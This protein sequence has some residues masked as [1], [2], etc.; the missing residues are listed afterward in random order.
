MSFLDRIIECN[1][2]DPTRFRPFIV[3]GQAVGHVRHEFAEHLT[4]F[5]D[6]FR[7]ANDRVELAADLGSYADRTAA[8]AT[9]LRQLERQGLIDASRHEPF[10][11]TT[12]FAAPALFE[13]ERTAVPYFGLRAFGLHMTG[14]VRSTKGIHLWIGRRSWTK[15][16]CPGMLDNTVAGGQ[17]VGISLLD[18][19]IKECGEEAG[20]PSARARQ[21]VPVGCISYLL[22]WPQGLKPDAMFCYDLELPAD[23]TPKNQDG[24]IEEFFL[25]PAERA[26][27]IVRDTREFKFNCNL[28]IIDFLIRHGLLPP[29]HPDYVEICRRLRQ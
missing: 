18:N 6:V 22:E 17:P 5:G 2:H 23:F 16:I 10:P 24:E 1:T 27:E 28:V 19:L 21:A 11:V 26:A 29:E 15:P 3:G 4:P 14:F 7:V 13:I 25:W 20:I 9:V 8:V 12:A